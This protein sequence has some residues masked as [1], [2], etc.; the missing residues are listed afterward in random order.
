MRDQIFANG[1]AVDALTVYR[2]YEAEE[3]YNYESVCQQK[4]S[5]KFF[6]DT[7][8]PTYSADV[9]DN[10]IAGTRWASY[11]QDGWNFFSP[12]NFRRVLLQRDAENLD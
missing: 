6:G 5:N 10:P 1:G 7:S 9:I 3:D 8:D 4:G 11:K 2:P 12:Q